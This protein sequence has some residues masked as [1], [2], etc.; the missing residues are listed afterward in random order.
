M[1]IAVI[2]VIFGCIFSL[3]M[4]S[5]IPSTKLDVIN[6]NDTDEV[7]TIT[8]CSIR[9]YQNQWAVTLKQ[10]IFESMLL[11]PKCVWKVVEFLCYMR[12]LFS[13]IVKNH[14]ERLCHGKPD[15]CWLSFF[16][17][18]FFRGGNRK[19]KKKVLTPFYDVQKICHTTSD[20]YLIAVN[21]HTHRKLDLTNQC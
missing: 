5:W 4:A 17:S 14:L 15:T 19:Y 11:K 2:L 10:C 8:G 21:L 3:A 6:Q 18:S 12:L 20:T 7:C 1:E 9:N 16:T 13:D